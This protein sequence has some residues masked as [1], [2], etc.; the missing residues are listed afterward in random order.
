M[1]NDLT[2]N[3]PNRLPMNGAVNVFNCAF[4]GKQCGKF[5]KGKRK[6]THKITHVNC[7][8]VYQFCNK[9]CKLQWIINA[10]KVNK[11]VE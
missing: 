4:C 5:S 1:Q 11:D 7:G 3:S 6:I 2:K 8:N 10:Q 9:N